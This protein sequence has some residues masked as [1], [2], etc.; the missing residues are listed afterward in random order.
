LR[1]HEQKRLQFHRL[2]GCQRLI[3]PE[4]DLTNHTEGWSNKSWIVPVEE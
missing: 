2:I 4:V 3:D 1:G